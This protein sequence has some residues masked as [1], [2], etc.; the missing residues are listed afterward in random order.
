MKKINLNIE[1]A[2]FLE[3]DI[4]PDNR[5]FFYECFNK[6]DFEKLSFVNDEFV[7]DCE[8]LSKKGTIRGLHY[9]KHPY[10]QGKLVRVV[11]GSVFDVIVD[12]RPKS[13]S[14][15]SYECINL[16]SENKRILWIPPGFAH[17][18]QALEEETKMQYKLTR[19]YNRESE[20]SIRFDDK[21]LS[22]DWP[23]LPP[24]FISEKDKN[25]INLCD[26]NLS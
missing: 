18:F 14:F 6:R 13:K 15:K 9:Q 7:F 20:V 16:S 4:Y 3:P 22:I 12:L 21:S 5:G 23:L 11:S 2:F 26:V 25:G 1:N 19:Y 10:E 8:S 17:G 24:L